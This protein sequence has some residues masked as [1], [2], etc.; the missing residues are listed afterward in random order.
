MVAPVHPVLTSI[1]TGEIPPEICQLQKLKH[2]YLHEN[3]LTGQ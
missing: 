1:F 3:K 2:L